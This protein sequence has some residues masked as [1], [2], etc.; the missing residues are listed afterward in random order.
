MSTLF[1]AKSLLEQH[2]EFAHN[3]QCSRCQR[4]F[5]KQDVLDEHYLTHVF[6]CDTCGSKFND[7]EQLTEHESFSHRFKCRRCPSRFSTSKDRKKHVEDVHVLECPSCSNKFNTESALL[8][9]HATAH[10]FSCKECKAVFESSVNLDQH[11]TNF[12]TFKC[13]RCKGSIFKTSAALKNHD[14]IAHT[15][16]CAYCPQKF[17]LPQDL[18]LHIISKHFMKCGKCTGM[19][20]CELKSLNEH[21]TAVH[22]TVQPKP[23]LDVATQTKMLRRKECPECEGSSFDSLAS[24]EKHRSQAHRIACP[25]C[26]KVFKTSAEVVK[27]SNLEHMLKCTECSGLFEDQEKLTKHT[28]KTHLPTWTPVPAP[29]IEPQPTKKNPG[30]VGYEDSSSSASDE[31]ELLDPQSTTQSN[32]MPGLEMK[33]TGTQTTIYECDECDAIFEKEVEIELHKKHSPFHGPRA[34]EC[35]ECRI[36]FSNQIE[37]LRHIESKLHRTKWVLSMI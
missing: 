3:L 17:K 34:L 15:S 21:V 14:D 31:D 7:P 35:T 6:H 20:F 18:R 26:E 16:P 4:K 25:H 11:V 37:L 1:D 2:H 19:Y 29:P 10:S 32:H 30:L 23:V 36:L 13:E 28:A 24:L 27:H 5:D 9:H 12:H 33:E 8:E 22:S